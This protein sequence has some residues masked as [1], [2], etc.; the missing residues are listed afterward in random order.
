[1]I[2]VVL[3]AMTQSSFAQPLLKWESVFGG[4]GADRAYSVVQTDD[5]GFV[6]AGST[7]SNNF[8]VSGLHNNGQG[9]G[10]IWIAKVSKTGSLVWQKVYGGAADDVAHCIIKTSDGGFIV[11]GTT[12]STDGDAAGGGYHGGS[13][14]AWIIKLNADGSIKWQKCYGG[15][16]SDGAN[17]IV[18]ASDGNYV[19][20]G[21]TSSSNGDIT[22]NQGIN[23]YWVVKIDTLGKLLWSSTF[24]GS[25]N[26]IANSITLAYDG[27]FAV[28]GYSSSA[29]GDVDNPLSADDFWIIKVTSSGSLGW[30]YNYGGSDEDE[31][32]AIVATADSGFAVAGYT[33]STDGNVRGFIGGSDFWV[34]KL[35]RNGVFV[36][37]STLG[38]MY[39]DQ[40]QS[41][42]QTADR[43]YI[44]VGK[45]N[46]DDSDVK[47]KLHNL[48]NNP[49][50]FDA[51]VTK[52]SPSG[53]LQWAKTYGG[54]SDDEAWGVIQTSDTGYAIAAETKSIDGDVNPPTHGDYDVWMLSLMTDTTGRGSGNTG[55]V[56]IGSEFSSQS[57]SLYP[58]PTTG[59]ARVTY[60]L[61]K[62]SDVH[63]ALFNSLGEQV[64]TLVSGKQSEGFHSLRFELGSLPQGEYFIHLQ[65]GDQSKVEGL[66]FT[67]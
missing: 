56:A 54:G 33:Y 48:P 16:L 19:F 65:A 6:F 27:S 36:W 2:I 4:S 7:M 64:K 32:N 63:V 66:L 15:S 20:A 49:L 43:G 40:A 11:A 57:I 47:T 17:S 41:I 14:D 10:D 8:D 34:I 35:N 55:A 60:D 1:M 52:L 53:Q 46:S 42:V 50:Y 45:T 61:A 13:G 28:A 12:S 29:D 37:Q 39:D 62:T 44:V 51:W 30:H 67:R 24:G 21:F 18:Q 25:D 5:G 23:D 3:A 31:A 22:K 26:D 58:N 9:D 38:G 59:T